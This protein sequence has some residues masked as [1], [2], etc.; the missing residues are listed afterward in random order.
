MLR[1]RSSRRASGSGQDSE[2]ICNNF[3]GGTGMRGRCGADQE[4]GL[5][6]LRVGVLKLKNK[7]VNKNLYKH[8]PTMLIITTDDKIIKN[9]L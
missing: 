9:K 7:D 8:L 2:E 5:D 3:H 4:T 6:K 1:L